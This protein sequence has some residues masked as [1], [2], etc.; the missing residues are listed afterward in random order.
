MRE[1]LTTGADAAARTTRVVLRRSPLGGATVSQTL[2]FGFLSPPQASLEGRR[3]PA[4]AFG[5]DITP[6][7]LAQRFPEAAAACLQ[8][9][10]H[11]ALARV[12]AAHPGAT[13]RL[14][15]VTAIALQDRATTALPDVLAPPGMAARVTLTISCS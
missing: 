7:A 14:A 2:V 3:Q 11:A 1:M 6:Q 10:L 5:V 15:R 12:V 4:A 9:G 8:P 13:P